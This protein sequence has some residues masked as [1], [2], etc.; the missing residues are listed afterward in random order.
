MLF[1]EQAVR[2]DPQ[3]SEDDDR[4]AVDDLDIEQKV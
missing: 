4:D 2:S 3:D 1:S